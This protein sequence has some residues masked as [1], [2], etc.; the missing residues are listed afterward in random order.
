MPADSTGT[1]TFALTFT[2]TLGGIP[3]PSQYPAGGW[4]CAWIVHEI[5]NESVAAASGCLN[6]VSRRANCCQPQLA[7]LTANVWSDAS[8]VAS[9]TGLPRSSGTEERISKRNHQRPRRAHLVPMDESRS[10]CVGYVS[11]ARSTVK[12]GMVKSQWKEEIDEKGAYDA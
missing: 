8:F 6:S 10:C 5:T 1:S 3:T 11:V 2:F 7:V 12:Q 9:T 4:A